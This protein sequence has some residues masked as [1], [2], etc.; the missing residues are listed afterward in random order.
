MEILSHL[1]GR[2]VDG[3]VARLVAGEGDLAALLVAVGDLLSVRG[4]PRVL[5]H[6]TLAPQRAEVPGA[7]VLA[8]HDVGVLAGL[9]GQSEGV[10]LAAKDEG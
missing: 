9:P 7:V 6:R 4:P 2:G 5:A 8:G 3:D 10:V 1:D